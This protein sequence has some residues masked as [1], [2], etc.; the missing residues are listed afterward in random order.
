MLSNSDSNDSKKPI[1]AVLEE[2]KAK[3]DE[4]SPDL[5]IQSIKTGIRPFIHIVDGI[6]SIF[7]TSISYYDLT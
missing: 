2:S 6:F 3:R 7:I 5:P 1:H 4:P